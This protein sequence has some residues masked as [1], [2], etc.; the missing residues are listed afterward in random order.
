MEYK[1][2][3]E[4]LNRAAGPELG[5]NVNQAAKRAGVKCRTQHVTNSK[6]KGEVMVYPTGFLDSYFG[7]TTKDDELP[8]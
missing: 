4:Y 3:F 5:K 2:L 8:F 1:S 7:K 6:Y